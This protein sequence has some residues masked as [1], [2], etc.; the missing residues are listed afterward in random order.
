M[1]VAK[2]QHPFLL[3]N[4][5]LQKPYPEDFRKEGQ[6]IKKE[7]FYINIRKELG[8]IYGYKQINKGCSSSCTQS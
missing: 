2:L 4:V 5:N 3:S 6:F 8:E 7:C 1:G